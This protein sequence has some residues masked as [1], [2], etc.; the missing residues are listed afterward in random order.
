MIGDYVQSVWIGTR[1][2]DLWISKKIGSTVFLFSQ[3]LN[4]W[5]INYKG[6]MEGK[7]QLFTGNQNRLNFWQFSNLVCHIFLL[8]VPHIYLR[9]NDNSNNKMK[10]LAKLRKNNT[11]LCT[12]RSIWVSYVIFQFSLWGY[13][14]PIFLSMFNF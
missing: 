11:C 7:S 6:V 3:A 9:F 8:L 2:T 5:Q 14:L 12:C 13:G 1:I 10:L 4:G